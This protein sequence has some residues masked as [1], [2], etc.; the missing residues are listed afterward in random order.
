MSSCLLALAIGC[1]GDDASKVVTDADTTLETILPDVDFE[2]DARQEISL[3]PD[4]GD[5]CDGNED[6]TSGYCVEGPSGFV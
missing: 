4:F 5:P 2:I 6:C 3:P 1:G